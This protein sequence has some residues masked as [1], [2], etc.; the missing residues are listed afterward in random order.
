MPFL[1]HLSAPTKQFA[2]CSLSQGLAVTPSICVTEEQQQQQRRAI[3]RYTTTINIQIMSS[4][5]PTQTPSQQAT[6][7]LV[8]VTQE[9]SAR[10]PSPPTPAQKSAAAT[11]ELQASVPQAQAPNPSAPAAATQETPP[12]PVLQT[13]A[14]KPSPSTHPLRSH[15]RPP[16]TSSA[17]ADTHH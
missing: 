9:M 5:T 2:P 7:P 14:P 13:Q 16:S 15:S 3:R 6:M 10:Y 4:V 17:P 12:P 11:Q 8:A 1:D